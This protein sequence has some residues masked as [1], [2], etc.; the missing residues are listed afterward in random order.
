MTQNCRNRT[1]PRSTSSADRH[2]V[3]A[4]HLFQIVEAAHFRS[5]EM[6]DDVAR[7]DQNPVATLRAFGR[8]A[9]DALILQLLAQMVGHGADLPGRAAGGNH[10]EVCDAGF[11]GEFDD[12]DVVR[13][14]V[15]QG[16]LDNGKQAPALGKDVLLFG[17]TGLGLLQYD[18]KS[19][20]S[21]CLGLYARR[22]F[23]SPVSRRPADGPGFRTLTGGS[24]GNE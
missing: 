8:D 17:P 11:V 3:H 19:P 18:P 5:E 9:Q 13:L 21:C 4:P 16:R 22:N 10:H 1:L 24:S 23:P 2:Q 14:V 20:V 6:D 15:L 12:D 7:V